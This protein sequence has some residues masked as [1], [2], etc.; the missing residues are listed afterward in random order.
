MLV[1][2]PSGLLSGG[3]CG[4]AYRLACREHVPQQQCLLIS[5]IVRGG[6]ESCICHGHPH[7][8]CLRRAMHSQQ[9]NQPCMATM[10]S[11]SLAWE[12]SK[13]WPLT[14]QPKRPP[15]GQRQVSSCVQCQ[16]QPH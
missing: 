15:C 3:T 16:Q 6:Q 10:T 1:R 5:H 2:A 4:A 13:P 14:I 8:L 11:G 12:P 7:K 9:H